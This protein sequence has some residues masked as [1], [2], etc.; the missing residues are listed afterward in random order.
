VLLPKYLTDTDIGVVAEP[1]ISGVGTLHLDAPGAHTITGFSNTR[2][3]AAFSRILVVQHDNPNTGMTNSAE[4]QLLGQEDVI[5]QTGMLHLFIMLD[6]E[7]GAPYN[8]YWRELLR[9]F[10]DANLHN[11]W[12]NRPGAAAGSPSPSRPQVGQM[13]ICS[14]CTDCGAG[15]DYPVWWNGTAWVCATGVEENGP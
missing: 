13:F 9:A 15:K 2:F 12:A 8:Y 5:G 1:D 7:E 14:D 6:N 4:L 3:G 11:V 10:T